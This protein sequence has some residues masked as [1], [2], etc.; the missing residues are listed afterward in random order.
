MN[1]RRGLLTLI[2][3]TFSIFIAF[4][5]YEI[6]GKLNITT[7]WQHQIFLSTINKLDDYYNA[8]PENIIQVGS[9]NEDGTFK[10]VG[11]NLPLESRFYR[12]YLIKEE[13]TEFDAC[14]YVERGDHNFIHLILDNNTKIDV[15]SDVNHSGPFGNY[16]IIGNIE[17]QNL[18]DLSMMIFPSFY[19]YQIKFPSELQFSKQKLN[20]DLFDFADTCQHVLVSLAAILN[21]DMDQYYDLESEKYLAFGSR[22][23]AE[24]NNHS[25]AEDY[26]RK[27]NYHNGGLNNSNQSFWV[28]S[29][30]LGLVIGLLLAILKI[31]QLQK[32]LNKTLSK[33]INQ[34]PTHIP[35][36]T[37][38]EE[39][40]L[41][42]IVDEK[43]NKEIASELFI[44]LSTVKTHI[45]KLY[46][47]LG[48][49][50]RSEAKS[51][52]KKISLNS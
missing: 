42:L 9:I 47:K 21:T 20:R 19:F 4:A 7:D 30:I 29:L 26:F 14:L 5:E 49:K 16:Q 41:S 23:S 6:K 28:F 40:I 22:L 17:N 10:L 48:A 52:A 35:S 45:N 13:N 46:A 27:M 32:K 43:S 50:T 24:L 37:K 44:E 39:K 11:N 33:E 25:Y 2:F 1:R 36:F 8:N 12:L 18:R 34:Q 51:L 31:Y 38:Q 15:Q 3:T